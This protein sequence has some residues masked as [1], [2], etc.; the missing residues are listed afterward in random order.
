MSKLFRIILILYAFL[1]LLLM[2]SVGASIVFGK[3]MQPTPKRVREIQRALQDHGYSAGKT[4]H[5]T[6]EILRG[7]AGAHGWQTHRAPDARVLIFLGLGNEHSD[8]DILNWPK[9]RLESGDKDGN[10]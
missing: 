2:L 8:P 6:Q 5:E 4:W 10:S 7:I 1:I 9:S 3:Q